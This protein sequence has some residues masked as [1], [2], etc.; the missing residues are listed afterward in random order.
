MSSHKQVLQK[1]GG[2]IMIV[3]YLGQYFHHSA[4][5]WKTVITGEQ[6]SCICDQSG[7]SLCQQS[8]TA[9]SDGGR[10]LLPD[11][12]VGRQLCP[13]SLCS[14]A[15]RRAVQLN[16]S[17]LGRFGLNSCWHAETQLSLWSDAFTAQHQQRKG[18]NKT[19]DGQKA[20]LIP[21]VLPS[22][23]SHCQMVHLPPPNFPLIT[24]YSGT[25]TRWK[26]DAAPTLQV[27]SREVHA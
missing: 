24:F 12:E 22:Y 17:G 16:A 19:E 10:T 4:L 21:S 14:A 8:H 25:L 20:W 1:R 18:G 9:R 6:P 15:R 5:W 27:V 3:L 11:S 23:P 2:P 26:K 13:F 7:V